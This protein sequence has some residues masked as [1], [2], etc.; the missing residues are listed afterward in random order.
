MIHRTL[1]RFVTDES[2]A[3][4]VFVALS[5]VAMVSMAALAIDVGMLFNARSEA[6]RAADSGALAGA[7]EF[8]YN[9][10]LVAEPFARDSA[11]S[12]A[13]R[14]TIRHAAIVP[15]EVGVEVLPADRIV[16]VTV[17]RAIPTWFARIFGVDQVT[18]SAVAA[19][20]AA[21]AGESDCVK[22]FALPDLWAE[23]NTAEDL[24]GDG[25]PDFDENWIY[26]PNTGD[27]YEPHGDNWGACPDG[28]T[29]TGYGSCLRTTNR[30]FGRE[31]KVK[32]TDPNDP[33]Q[34]ASGFFFPVRLAR[35][36]SSPDCVSGGG[37]EQGARTYMN[38][39]CSCTGGVEIG[40]TLRVEDG[41]MVG[42][43]WQGIGDLIDLDPG[44]T[45][46]P[47]ANGGQGAVVGSSFDNWY[48]S[49][50]VAKILLYPPDGI[51]S[52]SDKTFT[53]QNIAL[54]FFEEQK[55]RS[56]PVTARFLYY[57]SG[58]EGTPGNTA[59]SL[60]RTLRLIE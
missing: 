22:P 55:T 14:N 11:I 60:I 8:L 34:A 50:R 56:D 7:Q 31:L 45:W 5:A 24:D 1:E 3:T 9:G 43:T 49:P 23:T 16:R 2:G 39:I 10:P 19:A 37:L 57:A 29:Q 54:M 51:G 4:L 28:T 58:S 6:Q 38:N 15:G 33:W 26:D 40:D 41:N 13:T 12:Y 20:E 52:S 35:D 59:G 46:D 48:D 17:T 30:D 25:Y 36:P 42:P 53:V 18:V 21:T 47:S 32:V 27:R 44:A